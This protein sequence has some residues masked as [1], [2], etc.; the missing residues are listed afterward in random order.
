MAAAD[1]MPADTQRLQDSTTGKI[2][3]LDGEEWKRLLRLVNR[4]DQLRPWARYY[5]EHMQPFVAMADRRGP[6]H[7]TDRLDT[8]KDF[9]AV[10][11]V[12]M[13]ALTI[14]A[15]LKFGCSKETSDVEHRLWEALDL[16]NAM[17]AQLETAL[18][19]ADAPPQLHQAY[20]AYLGGSAQL[21]EA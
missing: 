17:E 19:R 18:K 10:R 7:L 16:M 5:F 20:R 8:H 21:V 15:D 1:V 6:H 14:R 9:I 11:R 12:L 13:K 3:Q 4:R 2:F